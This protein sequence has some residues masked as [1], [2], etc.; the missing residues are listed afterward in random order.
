[1]VHDANIRQSYF[2]RKHLFIVANALSSQTPL[3]LVKAQ[4]TIVGRVR[5]F[6]PVRK[7]NPD[8]RMGKGL[9]KK[10]G[11]ITLSGHSALISSL[12]DRTNHPGFKGFF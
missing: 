1:M 4:I 12:G 3:V 6:S 10:I 9:A 2:T 7:N 11:V 8:S 5:K